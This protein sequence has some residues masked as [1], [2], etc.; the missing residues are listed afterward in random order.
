MLPAQGPITAF[1]HHNTLHAFE[2]L[3]FDAAVRKGAE[4]FGCEPYLP[5]AA[6]REML[7][8]ERITTE[9]L[10]TVLLDDLG[11]YADILVGRLG[12]RYYLRLAMLQ[13]P[14]RMASHQE[15]Q[16]LLEESDALRRFFPETPPELRRRM[17]E[18]TRHWAMRDLRNG[19]SQT[20]VLTTPLTPVLGRLLDRLAEPSVEQWTTTRWEAFCLQL[21][22]QV[23]QRGVAGV[24]MRPDREVPRVRHRDWLLL[25]TGQDSDRLVH[26][27]LIRLC[28]AYLD[29]G[30]AN[31]T[32]PGRQ[33]GFFEAFVALYSQPW[34]PPDRWLRGLREELLRLSRSG[35][36]A[37]Q[38]I[39]ESLQILGVREEEQET[40]ITASLLSLRGWAGMI[41]QTETRGDRVFHPAPQGSLIGFLAIQLVL[42]RLA[43]SHLAAETLGY[44]GPLSE[45]R[46]VL[47]RM[48][49]GADL[50]VQERRAFQVFQL[51]Q[52][53]GWGPRDLMQL[54]PSEWGVLVREIEAFSELER[55]RV[56]QQAFERHYAVG[57]L[58]ALA[59]H[60]LRV[61]PPQD[62]PQFQ[63]CC[64]IDDR[65]ESF[66][67]HLEEVEPHCE[68]FGLAGFFG[69]AMYYRGAAEAHYLPLCPVVI[70]PGHYVCEEVTYTYGEMH[71]R[72]SGTRRALASASHQWHVGS[73]GL[74]PGILTALLGSAASI[75]LIARILFPRTTAQI[76]RLFG[77][78]V[79]PPPATLLKLE[80]HLTEP[81]PEPGHIGYLVPEMAGIVER[82]LCDMGL[83]S[84][85]SR[86]VIVIGHGSSSL[87]NPHESAYNCGACAGGRGGPNAR[88][89]A[90]MANDPRVRELL[91]ERGLVIPWTT[92]FLGAFHDTCNDRVT[93][94][95]LDSLPS[96]HWE[97]FDSARRCI[98]QARERNAH[99]RC[100]RFEAARLSLT[101]EQALRHVESRAENLA[102]VRPEYNHATNAVTIVGRRWRTRGLFLDRR[103]FL[104]SY[105]PGID[106]EQR[107]IL[108]RILQAVIPV[109]AGISLE[110][111][112][113]CVDPE[114][115]GCGSKLPHN[116]TSLLGVMIGAGSD[117]QP[118]LSRQMVEVHEPLR[119]LFVIETTPEAMLQIMERNPAIGTLCRH[120]WVQLATL[121]PQS[122]TVH[123]YRNGV[124]E[125]YHEQSL[126]L[127]VVRTSRDWYRGWRDHLGF[128]SVTDLRSTDGR[129]G[130]AD[131]TGR[132]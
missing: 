45:L 39:A 81:G 95:D 25:A 96:S 3:P 65:E 49:S 10:Q 129:N 112:F 28:A 40:F 36:G 103:A 123:V 100:R 127:P 85:F 30:V 62:V 118:G 104:A 38:S 108:S 110:Y 117:L 121:D 61:K 101:P 131:E 11:E 31:W 88:A 7:K 106:D 46:S 29:Q 50:S 20:G 60:S 107:T 22:W 17:I 111:Y 42:E 76:R 12:T 84:G 71:R 26:E 68:T 83:T 102:E 55:R 35:S 75:P 113:S 8:S 44:R 77:Q 4:L 51:A 56:Y 105:D 59:V 91:S 52:T 54:A 122:S 90:R 73:R 6:Y 132:R 87:N 24:P 120:E 89:F 124:F 47:S 23:C 125:V 33:Q 82:A 97:D 130:R 37:L 93:Y 43:L 74:L 64:C 32:M 48:P 53:R 80:R 21:L 78:M 58:D 128:A 5:E 63:V 109:C 70:K 92:V 119:Q 2:S 67:R 14:L 18:Q 94:F 69:V 115:W 9:D 16:W 98:D 13:H 126:E 41:W 99:E 86:L 79:E 1:V 19:R 114:G 34:G 116:I 27:L 72:R 57:L 15:L 66:R